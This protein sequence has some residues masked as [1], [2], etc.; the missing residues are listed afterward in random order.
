MRYLSI[1]FLLPAALLRL[2]ARLRR[3]RRRRRSER[4]RRGGQRRRRSRSSSSTR[5]S[6]RRSGATQ[7]QK[8]AFP[9]AGTPEYET[10][11]NQAV[12]YLVQR[13]EFQQKAD[14]LGDQ[15]HRQA[16]RRPPRADQEAVLRRQRHALQEAAEAAGPHRDA[17][18]RR[19][20]GAAD[21]GED[22]QEGHA[23]V[24]VTDA[25]IQKYY[26]DA[27]VAV[28]RPEQRQVAHILVKKKAL[29]DKL[30]AQDQGRRG[31]RQAREEVL[32]GSGLEEAGRQADDLEGPDRRAVR[33]DRVPAGDRARS[34]TRSR[35]IRLPH[36]QGDRAVKAAKTTPFTKVKESIRQQLLQQKKNEAMTKWVGQAEEGL[37][38]QDLVPDRLRAA[39]RPRRPPD[40]TTG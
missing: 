40:T 22:L 12:Q 4:R 37:R 27:P 21:P 13:A 36:H 3:R 8:R 5:C 26:D 14:E 29:A 9:K 20:Q 15:G 31:L 11:K 38:R 25:E 35:P 34:R 39:G 10:L 30:Y 23:D 28:R 19:H 32:T 24:K 33:P 17:G 1:S 2:L 6:T 7:T 16:D 18:E